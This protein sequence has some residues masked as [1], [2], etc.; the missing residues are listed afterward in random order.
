MGFHWDPETT[1]LK[2]LSIARSEKTI[3]FWLDLLRGASIIILLLAKQLSAVR[4]LLHLSNIKSLLLLRQTSQHRLTNTL[5]LKYLTS[6][7]LSSTVLLPLGPPKLSLGP[8]L[9]QSTV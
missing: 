3:Y 8:L 5:S 6:V 1:A 4:Y 2:S 9:Q 7:L